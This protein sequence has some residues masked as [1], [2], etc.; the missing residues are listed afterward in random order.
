[1]NIN[2]ANKFAATRARS[3]PAQ[4]ETKGKDVTTISESA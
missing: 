2:Q 4:A 3:L 1:L